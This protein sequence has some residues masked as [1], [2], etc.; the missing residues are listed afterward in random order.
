MHMAI[1]VDEYGQMSGVVTL[2]DLLEEIT[3]EIRDE[4]DTTEEV[5]HMKELSEGRWEA[6]GLA[7]LADVER[8][9]GSPLEHEPETNTLSGLFMDS[10]DR[11]PVKGDVLEVSG[12]RLSV[13]SVGQRRAGHVGI[14]KLAEP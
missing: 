12:F 14:E 3:G 11:L 6:D 13:L 2:E 1:I 5:H 4:T 7:P 10:L 9:I 8:M